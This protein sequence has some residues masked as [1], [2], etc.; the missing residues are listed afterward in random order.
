MPHNKLTEGRLRRPR[1]TK[2]MVVP[3]ANYN[4][5]LAEV[6]RSENPKHQKNPPKQKGCKKKARVEVG[7]FSNKLPG[8]AIGG[9]HMQVPCDPVRIPLLIRHTTTAI[10]D[11]PKI[12][13]IGLSR[14]FTSYSS[15]YLA[16]PGVE[17]HG[18]TP[19]LPPSLA[20]I[21]VAEILG[22]A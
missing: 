4:N 18:L 12:K 17:S 21:L 13:K 14:R 8:S 1:Q 5:L 22:T 20:G 19:A 10:P 15:V 6:P 2:S 3:S 16:T 7:S 9:N 11:H